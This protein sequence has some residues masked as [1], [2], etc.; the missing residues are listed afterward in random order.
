MVAAT[1]K[2]VDVVIV[3]LQLLIIVVAT[4]REVEVVIFLPHPLSMVAAT[5]KPALVDR[6]EVMARLIT[7]AMESAVL[8]I[9][10]L[11]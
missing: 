11:V 10:F 8:T 3:L 5:V 2:F 4:V 7:V 9:T 1:V 6:V